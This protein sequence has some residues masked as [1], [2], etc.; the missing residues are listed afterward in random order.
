MYLYLYLCLFKWCLMFIM[1]LQYK[2]CEIF[3]WYYSSSDTASSSLTVYKARE[4]VKY[5]VSPKY[6]YNVWAMIVVVAL[7][8]CHMFRQVVITDCWSGPW[9]P[10]RERIL[11]HH[12]FLFFSASFVAKQVG[13][14]WGTMNIFTMEYQYYWGFVPGLFSKIDK[15][16]RR[17]SRANVTIVWAFSLQVFS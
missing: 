9:N 5:F 15:R 4:S 7:V 11:Q 17:E 8:A 14:R 12:Y 3:L 16:K 1:S 6:F 2:K 10:A 13:G